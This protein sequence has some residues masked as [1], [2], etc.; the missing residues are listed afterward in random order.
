[1]C[2]VADAA[3]A[4]VNRSIELAWETRN[5]SYLPAAGLQHLLDDLHP[6]IGGADKLCFREG[7]LDS[8][9]ALETRDEVESLHIGP[10]LQFFCR[11]LQVQGLPRRKRTEGCERHGARKRVERTAEGPRL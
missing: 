8:A 7:D 2:K 1:M 5:E 9:E 4:M 10:A 11:I 3:M 6:P